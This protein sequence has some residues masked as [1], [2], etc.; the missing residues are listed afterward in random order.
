VIV[1]VLVT[2]SAVPRY[3]CSPTLLQ[4]RISMKCRLFR[5]TFQPTDVPRQQSDLY[6]VAM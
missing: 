6:W 1:E 4:R 5:D 2:A 3:Q